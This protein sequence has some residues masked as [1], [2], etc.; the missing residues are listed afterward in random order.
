[1]TTKKKDSTAWLNDELFEVLPKLLVKNKPNVKLSEC[2]FMCTQTA[3][4]LFNLENTDN[5]FKKINF[6]NYKYIKCVIEENKHWRL[7]FVNMVDK[8]FYYI[9]PFIAKST[10][11]SA[12]FKIWKTFIS[13]R[14]KANEIWKCGTFKHTKH[15]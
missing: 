13:N 6:N 14:T 2:Y 8:L 10:E 11:I 15:C 12:K 4:K 1:M 7:C 9:D 3:T 5:Y